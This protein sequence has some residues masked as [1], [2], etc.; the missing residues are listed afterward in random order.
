FMPLTGSVSPS[1][2]PTR[3]VLSAFRPRDSTPRVGLRLGLTDPVSGMNMGE[4]AEL[5][6]REHHITREMQDAFA[7][8]SHTR[9]VEAQDKLAQEICPVYLTKKNGEAVLHDNGPRR[10]QSM[11]VLAKLRPV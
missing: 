1:R 9:A 4:T 10:D 8:K 3:G 6:A 11:E 2:K 7:L 5:L